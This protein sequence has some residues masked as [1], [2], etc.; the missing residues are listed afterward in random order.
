[1]SAETK[2]GAA[3]PSGSKSGCGRPA[4][5]ECV[6]P[7]GADASGFRRWPKS[8]APLF[9]ETCGRAM[10]RSVLGERA[11]PDLA[12]GSVVAVVESPQPRAISEDLTSRSAPEAI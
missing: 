1:M 11:R 8:G 3:V 5:A 9:R 10:G 6:R 2:G 7:R 12:C 4:D